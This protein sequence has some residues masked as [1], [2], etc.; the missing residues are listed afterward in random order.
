MSKTQETKE[1]KGAG[2]VGARIHKTRMF[3][4][5]PALPKESTMMGKT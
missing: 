3:C 1:Q 4:V 2:L 5:C